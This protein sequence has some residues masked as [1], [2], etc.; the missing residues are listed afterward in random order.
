MSDEQF[1]KIVKYPAIG[2]CGLSCM[3]CP[4][5][6]RDTKSKCP[7]CKTEFRFSAPCAILT[8]ALK[9]K[10]V[11]FCWDCPEGKSCDKWKRHR[12]YSKT[13]DSFICYQKLEDNIV[14]TRKHGIEAFEEKQSRRV[15]LLKELL[16]E[17]NDGRSKSY[18]CIAATILEIEE[19]KIAIDKG[20]SISVN[21]DIKSKAKIMHEIIDDI[22]A[23]KGYILKLRK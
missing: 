5:H 21:H 10:G 9:K 20:K 13:R 4:N 11:E 14:F 12:E 16:N 18:Y 23:Q 2:A 3:L 8:C 6:N 7:G 1:F 22:A 19:L 15:G 17:F